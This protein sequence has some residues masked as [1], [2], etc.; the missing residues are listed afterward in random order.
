MANTPVY[1]NPTASTNGSGASLVDPKNTWNGVTVAPGYDYFQVAGTTYRAPEGGGNYGLNCIRLSAGGGSAGAPTTIGSCDST[2]AATRTKAYIKGDR[3]GQTVNGINAVS[4]APYVVIQDLDISLV[5]GGSVGCN[6]IT[7]G[8]IGDTTAN[9]WVIQR[10]DVHD[11]R[12]ND[13]SVDVTGINIRGVGNIVRDCNIYNTVDDGI[14]GRGQFAQVLRNRIWAL[15][16]TGNNKADCV[17]FSGNCTGL[18]IADNWLSADGGRNKQVIIVGGTTPATGTGAVI[19]NNDLIGDINY[20]QLLY[21]DMPGIRVLRNRGVN[22]IHGLRFGPSSVGALVR[23]N[24][25]RNLES[26]GADT[27]RAIW[28]ED[29]SCVA[30]GNTLITAI[31]TVAQNTGIYC[32]ATH[33]SHTLH[34]NII[35]GFWRG[36][37]RDASQAETY[38][39]YWGNATNVTDTAGNTASL[40][41]HSVAGDPMLQSTSLRPSIAGAAYRAGLH[42]GYYSQDASGNQRYDPPTIGAYEPAYNR[43]I[44]T[45]RATR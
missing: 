39:L 21:T 34:S 17:Q 33:T 20:Q 2:G 26:T 12:P 7:T 22:G 15:N 41:S 38:N 30:I 4:A 19:M 1:I 32:E 31:G 43:S 45:T 24:V 9:Y 35:Q 40:G 42:P 36:M 3:G 23:S 10:C 16:R 25:I 27:W 11:M 28:F 44:A 6:G 5:G 37:R 18:L 13:G 14:Q 29:N 8:S